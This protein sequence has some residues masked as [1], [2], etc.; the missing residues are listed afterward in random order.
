[1]TD[2]QTTPA[3]WQQ[4]AVDAEEAL[5]GLLDAI[6]E[7]ARIQHPTDPRMERRVVYLHSLAVGAARAVCQGTRDV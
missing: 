1:M 7:G 2:Q 4:R 5:R 6:D 3:D